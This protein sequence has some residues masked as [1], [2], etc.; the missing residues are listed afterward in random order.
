MEVM[1]QEA[2]TSNARGPNWTQEELQDL[3]NLWSEKKI[4][5]QLE[6]S[7]NK[8]VYVII[9]KA[10]QAQGHNHAWTQVWCKIKALRSAFYLVKDVNS[11]SGARRTIAPFYEQLSIILSKDAGDTPGMQA[12]GIGFVEEESILTH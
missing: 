12:F 6:S 8:L 1:E 3:I 9:A 5:D 7:R 4:I 2:D 10:M 11:R